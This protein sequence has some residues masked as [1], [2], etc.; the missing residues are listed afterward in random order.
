MVCKAVLVVEQDPIIGTDQDKDIFWHNVGKIVRRSVRRDAARLGASAGWSERPDTAM[1]REFK[2]HISKRCQTFGECWLRVKR[3]NLT[4]NPS[5][6]DLIEATKAEFEKTS[7]YQAIQGQREQVEG[8]HYRDK[9]DT[10]VNSWKVLRVIDKYSGAAALA[11]SGGA[12]GGPSGNPPVPKD[13]DKDEDFVVPHGGEESA[14]KPAKRVGEVQ[15]RP[16]GT[17]AA[18]AARTTELALVPQAAASTNVLESFQAASRDKM[19]QAI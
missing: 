8:L 9:A 4:G 6:E 1:K 14:V 11:A 13:C 5:E 19:D 16:T 3:A 7:G 17:G 15:S 18:K 10:W 12:R 2:E